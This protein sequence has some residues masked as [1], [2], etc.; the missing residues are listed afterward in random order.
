MACNLK[1]E[2][3]NIFPFD[4]FT[5]YDKD[6]ISRLEITVERWMAMV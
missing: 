3:I 2:Q 6:C 4:L 1:C 5:R